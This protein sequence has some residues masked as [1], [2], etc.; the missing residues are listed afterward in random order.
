MILER[1][2][3]W[4]RTYSAL[5]NRFGLFLSLAVHAAVVPILGSSWVAGDPAD[6]EP[7]T[8]DVTLAWLP[9]Q[10]DSP[11]A[12][13][14]GSPL[15]AAPPANIPAPPV[16]RTA[17]RSLTSHHATTALAVPVSATPSPSPEMTR[18]EAAETKGDVSPII[19]TA[20][21]QPEKADI[22]A[23]YSG[24]LLERLERHKNYP[25]L[26]QRRNEEGTINI[27]LTL[28]QDG[29]LMQVELVGSGPPR[30]VEASLAA[31]EAAA[32]FPPLPVELG[33]RQAAF[34]LPITYCM[35]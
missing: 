1:V 11:P 21:P 7:Q 2:E 35:R 30:L 31:V 34:N 28:A 24:L 17:P 13:N 12:L 6:P 22:L 16:N 14:S 25:L 3:N 4:R 8:I 5:P 10:D 20:D 9:P 32:P 26:S 27:R 19:A 23:R 18:P 29:H 33:S 15:P